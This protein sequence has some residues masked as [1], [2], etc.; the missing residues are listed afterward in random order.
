MCVKIVAER[1]EEVL[2]KVVA[3]QDGRIE[4]SSSFLFLY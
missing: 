3:I 4:Y 1:K 2:L